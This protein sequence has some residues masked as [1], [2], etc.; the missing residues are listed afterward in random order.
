M[1]KTITIRVVLGVLAAIVVFG[2]VQ[3]LAAERVEV[4]ELMTTDESGNESITRLWVVDH[5]GVEYLRAG[6]ENAQ[7]FTRLEATPEIRL[8][9]GE[10]V[11]KYRAVPIPEKR[12]IVNDLMLEKYTWGDSFF[13]TIFGSRDGSV[14]VELHPIADRVE[15]D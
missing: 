9:R 5:E 6:A 10:R 14:P 13:A 15:T 3:T 12:Q 2:I 8:R 7:W 4:V 1:V 11:I